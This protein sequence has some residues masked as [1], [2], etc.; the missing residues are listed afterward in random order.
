MAGEVDK[1]EEQDKEPALV[2]IEEGSEEHR[3]MQERDDEDRDEQDGGDERLGKQ[4][5][6]EDERQDRQ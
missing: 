5:T 1:R 6:S 3:A 2:V 4:E